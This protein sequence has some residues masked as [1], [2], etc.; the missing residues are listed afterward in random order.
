M[1][2]IFDNYVET[3]FDGYQQAT[4]KF[5]QFK[6][7]YEKF[8]PKD[9]KSLVLDIGIG[10]GE[11]LSCMRDWGFNY[12][13]VDISPSTVKFCQSHKLKCEVTDDTV[14]WLLNNRKKFSLITCLDVLEHVPQNQTINFLKAIKSS[15]SNGGVAI[16]QVPNL[17]SPY[18]YLHHFNDFT[19]VSG[20]VEHSLRQVLLAAGFKQIELYGF[21]EIFATSLK[22]RLRLALRFF[23]RRAV[24]FLRALNANPNPKILDPVIFAVARK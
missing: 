9:K 1:K 3:S 4:F 23:Y 8:L 14:Q 13:G 7:N 12:Q 20:F 21:E 17:Q 2:E 10:R 6:I 24:R 19:H 11:M 22:Q 15:L 18:G 16:I 5:K